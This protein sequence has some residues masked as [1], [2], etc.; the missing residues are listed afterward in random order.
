MMGSASDLEA[1]L[2]VDWRH[3]VERRR[4]DITRRIA[5]RTDVVLFGAGN[6][7]R[8][9]FRDIASLP[10]TPVAFVDNNTSIQGSEVEGL[11]VLGPDAA[12]MRFGPSAL[13]LITVYTNS[14]V[15]EQCR[16]LG[17]P[18][19]TCAE[20]SWALPGPHP[21]SFVFGIPERLADSASEIE[22]AAS[23]WADAESEAEYRSQ[24]RWRLLLDY[25]A[26]AM[27][28]PPAET[29]FPDDLIS[30]SD[31]EVFVDCGAFT[32]DTIEA[33][34]AA[35]GGKF[36]QIVAIEPDAVSRRDLEHRVGDWKRSGIGPIRVEPFAAG[37]R[38]ATVRFETTG[39]VGSS[40]GS[41]ADS[42]D[43]A[44]LDEILSDCAPTYIKF[45]VEGAEHDALIGASG[46]ILEN[47][48]VL[49][50]SLYH[51]PEDLW[52]LPLLIRS[53]APDYRLY[54]RRY[55]DERWETVCYAVPARRVKS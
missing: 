14:S 51:K 26:L 10:F 6:L 18:W 21:P 24:I 19:V 2:G 20:L 25:A 43:M 49:A 5:G 12:A 15:M 30:P 31:G 52:D 44:P 27:P 39:T 22:A 23:I 7:G 32:G 17:V 16:A 34:L 36:E 55:S 50:V 38:R 35:R 9:V 48:P 1:L 33:F 45:D 11:E 53:L 54:L 47:L 41:G 28:R 29:Y 42:V 40:V 37:S 13:W 3:A 4:L 8:Q 46:T